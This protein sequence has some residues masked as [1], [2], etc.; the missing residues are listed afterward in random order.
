MKK[1]N[2]ALMALTLIIGFNIAKA[3]DSNNPWAVS[4]GVNVV[5][6]RTPKDIAGFSRDYF[7]GKIED[8]NMIP[9]FSRLSVGR[10]LDKGFSL[11]L[12]LSLNMV[13][14][15]FNY[16]TGDPLANDVFM[17]FDSKVKYD[18]NNLFGD[19]KWFD[20]FVLLGGGYSKIGDNSDFKIGAGYG[21][22]LWFNDNL[23]LNFQ[24]DYNHHPSSTATDYFQHSAGLILRFGGDD[25]DSDGDGISNRDDACPEVFG[26][27]EYKGCPDSDGDGI[28]DSK[29][30]CP[31]KAGLAALNGC[32]DTDGDGIAD[33]D[34]ACPND[35]GA[36]STRGCPDTDGD[37]VVDKDDTCP[38]VAGPSANKGCPWPDSDGDG[39]LD[40]D[41]NCVNEAGPAS[42]KGCPKITQKEVVQLGELFKT[43]YFD[44]GK[45][46]FK[47]ETYTNLNE[48][49]Q[50]M[51]KYSSAKF[52]ISGYTDN[53]GNNVLNQ[54]LSEKRAN[55]VKSYL[56]SKGVSSSNLR[57]KGYGEDMPIAT[58][59]TKA[60]KA[61][62]RRVEVKLMN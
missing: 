47:S 45:D 29:D 10:Y 3:Q 19:T 61:Q 7:N 35:K 15:G 50:I 41:D 52:A 33:K 44:T 23:G 59:N 46:T 32:P 12:A 5:D 54:E 62:N 30:F 48:A 27:A 31:N 51:T 6:I 57:A 22:N 25:N 18:L 4:F 16:E 37:G 36:K 60:G 21:F 39:V 42:N 8:L 14:K 58:N 13:E 55:A 43:V 49:A 1:L 38:E 34:D 2:V 26:L 40:K 11:Q 9:A 56:I 28:T 53:V 17:A 24:S 20:P